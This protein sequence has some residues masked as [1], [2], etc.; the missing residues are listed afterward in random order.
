[1]QISIK[2]LLFS[3]F[4]FFLKA[5]IFTICTASM[6]S[7]LTAKYVSSAWNVLWLSAP[8][9]LP[10]QFFFPVHLLSRLH[11]LPW[12]CSKIFP[13]AGNTSKMLTARKQP[14]SQICLRVNLSVDLF[15]TKPVTR[16][17]LQSSDVIRIQTHSWRAS[18]ALF[19]LFYLQSIN[20]VA[21]GRT[22]TTQ[23]WQVITARSWEN[24]SMPLMQ[25]QVIHATS[26][27]T[28]KGKQLK[29]IK[30]STRFLSTSSMMT[31]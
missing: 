30:L 8:L 26:N 9:L 20:S 21:A 23:I 11:S 22:K 6:M 10:F 1:M 27:R 24:L 3:F 29:L 17:V 7:I 28:E 31:F 19:L 16:L 4:F 14:Q 18:S 13:K 5:I 15:S 25:S 12:D 2:I